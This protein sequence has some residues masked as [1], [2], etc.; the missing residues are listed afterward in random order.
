[1]NKKNVISVI[2]VA[3]LFAVS[4]F[5][6][7]GTYARYSE[8]FSGNA[9]GE[10]AAWKVNVDGSDTLTLTFEPENETANVVG[11]KIAP[12]RKLKA[13]V[14]LDLTGTEVAV[15]I[16]AS[17]DSAQSAITSAFGASADK[18]TVTTSIS[19]D[20]GTTNGDGTTTIAL[21]EGAAFK[22]SD[23]V[24]IS[25]VL[26]WKNDDSNNENDTEVGSGEK[27]TYEIPITLTAQQHLDTDTHT[28]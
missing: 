9:N 23:K 27:L 25:V 17:L 22:N 28:A 16:K 13:E 2:V 10:I 21:K 18:V 26:E 20:A 11:S 8:N 19:E 4:L 15:D 24:T 5:Y 1:M 3:V 14:E 6:I 12:G 7:S